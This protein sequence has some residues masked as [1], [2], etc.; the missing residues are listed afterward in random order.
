MA[1]HVR[2]VSICLSIILV[3][4]TFELAYS[5]N[6]AGPGS[7]N[8]KST[9]KLE[10]PKLNAQEAVIEH[11]GYSLSFNDEYKLANWV[12]YD[13]TREET[14]GTSER[15]NNFIPDPLVPTGIASD[16][17]YQNSGYDRGHLAP[18]AD[19]AWSPAAMAE[20][21]YSS[22][23][24]PQNQGFNRG[25]WKKLELL[26]RK[27]A[28]QYE[29]VY[30][31]TGPVLTADLPKIGIHNVAV[32]NYFFKVILD[33]TE[34]GL[35]GIGFIVANEKS[36]E[37]LQDYAITIDSVERVTGIDFFPLLPDDQEWIIE[38]TV[39]I[40]DWSW[41]SS[42]PSGSVD[43]KSSEKKDQPV[44][45]QCSGTTKSGL[46]CKRMTKSPNGKCREHG[47]D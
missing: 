23:M 3:N 6:E 46:R 16:E 5:Q 9:P 32:P 36:R 38:S 20:S 22:N 29:S 27:W 12:A 11:T 21:F 15:T 35:K 43:S 42:D 7:E 44:S 47:G 41:E 37:P 40:N 17:D 13:L 4:C 24:S 18:A 10:I 14:R 39:N 45:V 19:M 31:V 26:V 28:E 2:A 34:P 30:I 8:I 1:N 25:I 33:Y